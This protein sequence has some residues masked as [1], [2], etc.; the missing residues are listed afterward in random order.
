MRYVILALL[1]AGCAAA[2][3][4]TPAPTPTPR[5]VEVPGPIPTPR[6]V[7]VEVAPLAC[8]A[9]INE[10]LDDSILLLDFVIA[11]EAA[12]FDFPD[13]DLAEFGARVEQILGD[14]A[15]PDEDAQQRM[16][17]A[18]DACLAAS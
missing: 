5:I 8:I 9:T 6:I 7:E 2:P 18:F 4:P 17:E 1:L 15:P 12:Y 11:I 3:V 13:E 16:D 10:L 14:R